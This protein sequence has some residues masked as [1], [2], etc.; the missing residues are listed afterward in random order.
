[1]TLGKG[2]IP[3]VQLYQIDLPGFYLGAKPK[4]AYFEH[5]QGKPIFISLD[6]TNAAKAAQE[7]RTAKDVELN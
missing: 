3:G 5:D 6:S 1:M 7:T 4:D 2:T